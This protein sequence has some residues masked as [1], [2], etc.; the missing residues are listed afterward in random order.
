MNNDDGALHLDLTISDK[1]FQGAMEEN[2]R[3]IKG[4]SNAT[5]AEG[6]KI[7]K[8]FEQLAK[9]IATSKEL[10]AATEVDVKKM[11]G[12][13]KNI[14]PGAAKA[15]LI[16]ELNAAKRALNEEKTALADLE[17]QANAAGAAH[18][19][20]RT[21]IR[22][23]TEELVRME[24]AGMRGTQEYD[25]LQASLG[26]LTQQMAHA[27]KQAN[28]LANDQVGLRGLIQG[29]SGVAGMAAAAQGAVALFAG[30]NENLV[31]IQTK[32]QG[33][34]SIAI[35]LQQTQQML[36]KNEAFM[37]GVVTK[38]K[39]GLAAAE[40]RL[41]TALGVSTAAARVMMATFTLGLTAAITV[42]ITAITRYVNKTQEAKKAA[43]EFNKATAEAGYQSM[44]SFEKMRLEWNSLG[45]DMKAKNKFIKDNADAFEDLGIQV[46]G[47]ADAENIFVNNTEAFRS[48]LRQRAMALAANELAQEKYKQYLLKDLEAQSMKATKTKT[49]IMPTAGEVQVGPV[50]S[51]ETTEYRNKWLKTQTEA[52]DLLTEFNDLTTKGAD[53]MASYYKA[54]DG[55]G[56]Q[57]TEHL[58]EKALLE[59]KI[60]EQEKLLLEAAEA[61]N[62]AEVKAIAERIKGLKAELEMREMLINAIYAQMRAN[63]LV[64]NTQADAW[65]PSGLNIKIGAP[66]TGGKPAGVRYNQTAV[67]DLET[68]KGKL[69]VMNQQLVNARNQEAIKKKLKKVDDEMKEI[70]EDELEK[71]KEIAQ[72]IS[73]TVAI[74]ERAGF[75]SGEMASQLQSMISFAGSIATGDYMGAIVSGVGMFVDQV[76]RFF[77]QTVAYE[78]RIKE[79]N[80]ILEEQARLVERAQQHG[81]EQEARADQIELQ[82]KTLK[83]TGAELE[84]WEKKL[85]NSEN[86]WNMFQSM[87]Y[88]KRKQRVEDL[89]A[90]YKAEQQALEEMEAAQ[91]Y[92]LTGGMTE[93]NLADTI[94]AGLMEGKRSF[95]DFADDINAILTQAVTSA[96]SAKILGPAIDELTN[97]LAEA[98]EDGVLSPEEAER[99]RT[100]FGDIAKKGAEMADASAA[101]LN[102]V[103]P[104][105]TLSGA[106]KGITEDAAGV[107]AGQMNAIRIQQVEST[108]V[109]R[110]QLS[111]L[112]TIA[113]NTGYN[114]HLA[115]IDRKLDALSSDPLRA[116]GLNG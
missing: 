35:G 22:Q 26:K 69:A 49:T 72:A 56:L 102:S 47:T 20:L 5:A 42:A 71:R 19:T 94:A 16:S 93:E 78:E 73:E 10:I 57:T 29:L 91:R 38:A 87:S 106:I 82:R 89:T 6:L 39:T 40:L 88:D 70:T 95:Q 8:A 101:A 83:E 109:L 103:Q 67:F 108:I 116:T 75:L 115:S 63:E 44:A 58:K 48:A 66:S 11:E 85:Y 51:V 105:K 1:Q 81:G 13:L 25:D 34:M 30:E 18:V 80:T 52:N 84:K 107:L 55:L 31:K 23:M 97:Y 61:G 90:Q 46:R 12:V 14:A 32:V 24:A 74:L 2:L 98:M 28:T 27:Q 99:Y 104:D 76:A 64:T 50:Q 21:Q 37:L 79:M 112:N 96:I 7:E 92:F 33:L 43:Q 114:K 17:E 111:I 77:D 68:E 54:L 110:Q 45:N 62:K 15:D 3:R 41:A 86:A 53:H 60:A 4:F 100:M 113:I 36:N 59:Q 65:Q 9:K